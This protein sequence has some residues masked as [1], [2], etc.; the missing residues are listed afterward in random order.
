[1]KWFRLWY[2]VTQK[3]VAIGVHFFMS[4]KQCGDF[5]LQKIPDCLCVCKDEAHISF[6]E[7]YTPIITGLRGK[8]SNYR[9]KRRYAHKR[10]M[11]FL[12]K[13]T[14]LVQ[15]MGIGRFFPQ[16][17]KGPFQVFFHSLLTKKGDDFCGDRNHVVGK[18]IGNSNIPLGK[19]PP[20]I[21]RVRPH[22]VPDTICV[23]LK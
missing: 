9:A 17:G 12:Y 8:M 20:V 1:M 23:N 15:I 13:S 3:C 10:G 16:N 7:V 19:N 22:V 4:F 5:L 2:R 11:M 14:K 21:R 18:V 6:G